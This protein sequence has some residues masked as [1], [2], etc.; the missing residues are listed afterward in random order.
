MNF[1]DNAKLFIHY[2]VNT[3]KDFVF[4]EDTRY[5]SF[6]CIYS[7]ATEEVIGRLKCTFI[8]YLFVYFSDIY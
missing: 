3:L 2:L 7:D 8:C 1:K 6:E 4:H 5:T